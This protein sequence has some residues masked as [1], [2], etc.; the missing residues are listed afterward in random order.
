MTIH[1]ELLI[2]LLSISDRAA[3]GV[4]ADQGIP[5]LEEWFAQALAS[6]WRTETRLIPDDQAAIESALIELVDDAGCDLVLT[7]GGTGPAPR[8][9]T[10]EA[11]RPLIERDIPGVSEAIRAYGQQRTPYSM[12]SR[13]VSGVIGGT[14]V[15]A[16]PGSTR[17]AAESMD[18]VF[19]HL[20]HVF[21]ILIGARHE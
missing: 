19:P 4:Y 18:A 11:L 5:A 9:V 21:N 20:L 1:D 10:P 6:P 17:G 2:G 7:T 16:L 12:L 14:L 15:L 13:C 8:D 3:Q